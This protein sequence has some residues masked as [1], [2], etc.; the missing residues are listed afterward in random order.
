LEIVVFKLSQGLL[1]ELTTSIFSRL[2]APLAHAEIVAH[3]LVESNLVG[4]AS[5]GVMRI[6]QYSNAIQD[7]ELI[8]H[9]NPQLIKDHVAGAVLDGRQGF[10]QVA[11]LEAMSLAIKKARETSVAAVTVY[12]SYHSG[13]LG[14]YTQYAAQAGLIGI[15]MVNAG[16]G[17][18][19]VVPFGGSERRLA[20]NPF[21][22]SAPSGGDFNPMLDV[23]TS[24]IPEGKVRDTHRRGELLPPGCIVDNQG[25]PSRD[26]V[27]FY[28]SPPGALL[29][30]G[31]PIGY[32]GFGLAFMIDILAGV[33][34]GAGCCRPENLPARDGLLFIAIDIKHFVNV[35]QFLDQVRE[36]TEYVKSCPPSPGFDEVFAPGELEH[37]EYLRRAEHGIELDDFTWTEIKAHADRLGIEIPSD[38]GLEISNGQRELE[39]QGSSYDSSLIP[40]V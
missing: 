37:Q 26:P 17:G 36:L 3:H 16:G 40:K 33:L 4:H 20:T 24:M 10:G 19:S 35:Q 30:W 28:A 18:Q 11:G 5:H 23:A 15:V 13:R 6:T 21:S 7:G 2:G 8:P 29:P 25:R 32:K 14:A 22:I 12:D 9:A 34:S 38:F 1:K 39:S 27:D 31:G